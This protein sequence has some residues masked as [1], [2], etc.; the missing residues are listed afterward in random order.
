M[1]SFKTRSIS[2]VVFLVIVVASLFWPLSY[3]VAMLFAIVLMTVEYFNMTVEKG[4]ELEKCLSIVGEMALFVLAFLTV[5]YGI[6]PK[7]ML[8]VFLP[9]M[10]LCIV[11]LYNRELIADKNVD[12]SSHLFFPV[13]YIALPMTSTLLLSFHG[14]GYEYRL[15][16]SIFIMI[17]LSDVGAYIFGMSFGQKPNSRKLCPS[18]SPKKSWAGF[19]GGVLMTFITMAVLWWTGLLDLSIWHCAAIAAI[20]SIF[21]VYGDLFESLLKRHYNV[22]DAGKIMPGHGG[23]LDR[24][25]GA[26][27]AIPAVVIYLKMFS[28]I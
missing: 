3:A 14:A 19:W 22:K 13:L 8:L 20:I 12:K 11:M 23:L 2:A 18:L 16:L 17:W 28:I 10:A 25:D 26:L 21:G 4:Y 6:D 7:Y 5:K 15:L 24:F 1:S 27:F 9:Y